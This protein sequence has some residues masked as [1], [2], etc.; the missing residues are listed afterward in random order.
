MLRQRLLRPLP[1]RRPKAKAKVAATAGARHSRSKSPRGAVQEVAA[2]SYAASAAPVR[3]AR[4]TGPNAAAAKLDPAAAF[5]AQL[6]EYFEAH[7]VGM[8]PKVAVLVAKTTGRRGVLITKLEAKYGGA[9]FP[10]SKLYGAAARAYFAR[11]APGKGG[12]I[13]GLLEKFKG[14]EDVLALKLESKFGGTFFGA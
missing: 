14:R 5:A 6:T 8:L 9:H 12:S 3:S 4:P 10:T 1:A 7:D 11:V 13:P 2:Y